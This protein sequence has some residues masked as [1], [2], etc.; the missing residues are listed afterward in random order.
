MP[1][2]RFITFEGVEGSGKTTQVA[3]LG[4]FL[5]ARGV[6]VHA[7]R[8]PGGTAL[9]ERLRDVLLDPASDPIP[10]AELLMLEAARSQLVNRVVLPALDAGDWV[11]SDR[12]SDS[13]LAYQGAA[14][15]LGWERVRALNEAACG[16]LA[17]DR[18]L[19]LDL[20]VE[21]ALA[22]ARSRVSTTAANR[23]FEDEA[24]GFHRRV[25]RAFRDLA[26]EEPE[27]VVVVDA[28]GTAEEVHEA[29][30]AALAGMLP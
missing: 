6:S 9:G 24:L 3:A 27:R 17:P 30:L 20:P 11:L 7:T 25:A 13:S 23:R 16:G 29:V 12:F 8:E 14:R 15:G 4:R 2:G 19:V 22:R 26:V 28:S 1:R 21:E 5:A 10:L 18:T